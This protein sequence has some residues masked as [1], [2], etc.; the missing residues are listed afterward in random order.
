MIYINGDSWS[1]KSNTAPD[2]SWPVFLE[3]QLNH[4]VVNDS[5]GMGSNTRMLSGLQNFYIQGY[6]PDLV[7]ISLSK[8]ARYHIPSSRI[9]SWSIGFT[10]MAHNDR[11][12]KKS[13][14]IDKWW[15]E[16]V[17]DELAFVY[18][19]YKT[20]WQIHEFCKQHLKCPA[21]FFN[22]YDD[23]FF[24]FQKEIFGT[25]EQVVNWVNARVEDP[26][27]QFTLE[28]INGFKFFKEQY[29]NWLVDTTS[30]RNMLPVN[31]IDDDTG[32]H[33]GHPSLDGH[34]LISNY[35]CIKL[36][37]MLPELYIK[38]KGKV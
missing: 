17:Y 36:E 33:S 18:Q 14:A 9:S 21:I 1:Q 4:T 31:F 10:G 23:M 29:K 8:F 26:V 34:R 2:Y 16:Q 7:I 15:Q 25:N 27:D 13:Y 20:I 24:E 11:H 30:W 32:I 37:Q 5:A 6:K 3:Q 38:L 22:A 28:Y 19:N 35:V 12:G